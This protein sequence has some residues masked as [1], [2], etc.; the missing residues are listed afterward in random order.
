MIKSMTGVGRAEAIL[1][2]WKTKVCV[3][4]R[5]L[6]HKYLEQALR[7]PTSLVSYEDEIR[8]LI[9]A[10]IPRGYIQVAISMEEST[11]MPTLTLD[12]ALLKNYLNL[13]KKLKEKANLS[14]ELDLNMVLTFP[15]IIKTDKIEKATEQI[16]QQV[17][18]V[19]NQALNRLIVMK[20]KEGATLAK[21]MRQRIVNIMKAVAAIE[22]RVPKRL[23][24]RRNNLMEQLKELKV[25]SDPKRVWEEVAYIAER[26]D[27]SE[28]CVRLRS[29]CT[30]FRNCLNEAVTDGLGKKL[31]FI[32]QEMLREADTLSAKA[33]DLFISQRVIAVKGEIE[34]LKE[35]VRNVE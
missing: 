20:K 21:D 33:R 18:K 35:Q 11:P 15:G 3:E 25:N 30:M 1:H 9:K 22:K 8:D 7:L 17:K 19:L 13:I 14:G 4:I 2:P 28:E 12:D 32:L 29:H 26:L 6:N 34:K 5:S 31:D 10:K 23:Q 16:W 24:E 27:I